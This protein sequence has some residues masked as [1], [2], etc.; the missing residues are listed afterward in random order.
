[1][2]FRSDINDFT[3]DNIRRLPDSP[4]Q[5]GTNSILSF[6]AVLP[7]GSGSLPGSVLAT[8][9][10]SNQ[11]RIL[12]VESQL[13]KPIESISSSERPVLTPQQ[14]QNTVPLRIFD[15]TPEKVSLLSDLY[16]YIFLYM[17]SFLSYHGKTKFM[18]N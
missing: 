9:F 15:L 6:Y 10:T 7:S 2:C 4:I 5:N 1:M 18:S 13:E 14:R 17:T 12:S 8:I 11:D 3:S 16:L